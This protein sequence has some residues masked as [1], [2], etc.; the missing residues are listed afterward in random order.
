MYCADMSKLQVP[1]DLA[2]VDAS[3][4]IVRRDLMVEVNRVI[5]TN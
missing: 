2:A 5:L 1:D 3:G 4:R